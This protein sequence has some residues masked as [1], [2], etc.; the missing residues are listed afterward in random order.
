MGKLYGYE[1]KGEGGDPLIGRC[2]SA[3]LEPKVLLLS[4]TTPEE[5]GRVEGDE[6]GE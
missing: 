6:V 3:G 4:L 2:L 5:A 1:G